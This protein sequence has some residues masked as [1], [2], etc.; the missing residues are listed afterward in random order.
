MSESEV[1]KL[2]GEVKELRAEIRSLT[3]AFN[4]AAYGE[5]FNRCSRNSNRIKHIEGG[6]ELC[7]DRI[8]GVKKWMIAGLVAAASA[9]AGFAWDIIRS[10]MKH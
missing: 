1:A 9:L 8:S 3:E 10:S 7:H 6:V 4:R 5:G 2:F